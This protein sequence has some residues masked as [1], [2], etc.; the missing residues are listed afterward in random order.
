MIV[1]SRE[2]LGCMGK[3][4]LGYAVEALNAQNRYF[5]GKVEAEGSHR[6]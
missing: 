1:G 6:D 5:S 3:V 4:S 2:G